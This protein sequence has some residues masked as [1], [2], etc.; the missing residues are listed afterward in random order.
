MV[1]QQRSLAS[2]GCIV[3]VGRDI[4]TFVVP[5]AKL[6]IYLTATA[7]TRAI[8][9]YQDFCAAGLDVKFEEILQSMEQRDFADSS[10]ENSPLRPADDA[11]VVDTNDMTMYQ[12]VDRII[13]LFKVKV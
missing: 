5:D 3:I 10:R 1:S 7:Q 11:E 13:E 12:V 8:R 9:R 2:N 6:K 4:G